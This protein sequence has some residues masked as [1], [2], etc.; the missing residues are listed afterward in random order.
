M[1]TDKK[2]CSTCPAGEERWEGYYSKSHHAN[3]V[4]YDYRSPAGELF[5]TIARSLEEAR[6]RRDKWLAKE[7]GTR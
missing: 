1:K 6:S 2:G 4:Q 5:T 3:L 7:G